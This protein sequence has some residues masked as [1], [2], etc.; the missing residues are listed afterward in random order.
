MLGRGHGSAFLRLLAEELK[1]DGAPVV[2]IDPGVENLRARRAYAR[3]GFKGDA[4]VE[5]AEGLAVLMVFEE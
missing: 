5:T 3:A 1:R 4:V 2:A